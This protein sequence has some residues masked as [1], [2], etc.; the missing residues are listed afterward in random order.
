MKNIAKRG[1]LFI[2]VLVLVLVTGCGGKATKEGIVQNDKI[3]VYTSFYAM[4]D[5]ANKIGGDKINLINLVPSGTEPHDWEPTPNDIVKLE[6]ADVFIYNGVGMEHWVEKVLESIDNEQLIA[7]ETTRGLKLLEGGDV[8]E[9]EEDDED[10]EEEDHEDLKYDP[11]VWLNP[12]LAK[13]QM[14][15][16]KEAFIEAD[17]SNKEFYENNY[18]NYASKLDEL[19]EE[20]TS[21]LSKLENK[22]IIVAHQAYGYLCDAFGLN[23]V[24]IE[25]LNADAEPSPARMVEIIKFAQENDI[26]VIFFEELVSPKVAETIAK[27]IGAET[28]VLS[29]IEGLIEEDILAGKEYFSVMRD[30]LEALKQALK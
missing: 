11:H 26:K 12:M 4:Y 27:E 14:A 30:N 15:A 22:D 17:P 21:T 25:G 9:E 1:L 13:Q 29:P 16:I 5:F 23:Q 24:P 19:F 10:E 3:T 8:H 2:L 6:K 28:A 7:V 18:I 20:F